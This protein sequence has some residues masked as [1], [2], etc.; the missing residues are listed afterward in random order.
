MA[1]VVGVILFALG[2]LVSLTL[3]EVGHAATARAFGMKVTRFF[4]GYGPTLFS[5]HRRGV[6]YGVKAIPAGA[7][8]KIVGMTDLDDVAAADEAR[9]MWR[10]PLWKRTLVMAA[11]ALTHFALGFVILWAL[12]AFTPLPDAGQLQREPVRVATVVPASG[13]AQLG[14][15]PGDTIIAVDGREVRGWDALTATVRA[16]GGRR[17]D[18]SYQRA[19][20][21]TT[22]SVVLP[23]A[24]GVG[25]LGITPEVP[26]STAGPLDAV[27]LASAQTTQLFGATATALGHLPQRVPALWATLTGDHR[28]PDTPISL[29]GASHIGGEL[30]DRHDWASFLLMLASLNFFVGMFNLLPILP[31]DGGHIAIWWFERARS[32]LYAR[33]RRPDPGRVDYYRLAPVVLVA[34]ALFAAFTLLSVAADLVNPAT[35]PD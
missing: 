17:V 7:F 14:L 34:I 15:R 9:A 11:G 31:A 23:V 2:I 1:Y 32:W 30:A 21:R 26:T 27:G 29:V 5:V 16:A 3:H 28:A 10:F 8:V 18:V 25:L 20:V 24:H 22:E 19:G 4:I 6:E 12:F 33:L 35:L 13:A